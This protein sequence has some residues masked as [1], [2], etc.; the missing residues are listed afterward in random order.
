MP[1]LL[2]ANLAFAAL[3]AVVV[4]RWR[5][6]R[7]SLP[8]RDAGA[9]DLRV[10][11]RP[12]DDE[13]VERWVGRALGRVALVPTGGGHWADRRGREIHVRSPEALDGS[14]LVELP[15]D[16]ADAVVAAVLDVLLEEGYEVSQTRGRRVVL[17]R[18]PDRMTLVAQPA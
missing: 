11:H 16:R 7:R 1:V 12:R 4:W 5:A 2:V 17:R 18:G 3:A 13:L 9:V 10:R 6:A 8:E 15:A 14:F